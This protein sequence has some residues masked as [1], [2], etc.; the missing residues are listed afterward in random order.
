M[1][2]NITDLC[3]FNHISHEAHLLAIASQAI[4]L[5]AKGQ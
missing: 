4:R 2:N 1:R 3:C 5:V